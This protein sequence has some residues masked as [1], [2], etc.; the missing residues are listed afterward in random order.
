VAAARA[1]LPAVDPREPVGPHWDPEPLTDAGRA[2]LAARL[3]RARPLLWNA[4]VLDALRVDPGRRRNRGPRPW[5][6]ARKRREPLP[7]RLPDRRRVLLG[8]VAWIAFLVCVVVL[9]GIDRADDPQ[10][11][12][13]VGA[14]AFAVAAGLF[15]HRWWWRRHGPGRRLLRSVGEAARVPGRGLERGVPGPGGRVLVL[16]G[17]GNGRD[18]GRESDR[19]EL[20]H[21]RAAPGEEQGR[22]QVRTLAWREVPRHGVERPE[23][24]AQ[25][26]WVIADD[27][28][29]A[30]GRAERDAG[31]IRRINAALGRAVAARRSAELAREP[32]AW[33]AVLAATGTAALA[34][35]LV[36]VGWN[37]ESGLA[38]DL[39]LRSW[40]LAAGVVLW[41]AAR[42]VHDPVEE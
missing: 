30:T 41:R 4:G 9:G 22:L 16:H 6:G 7:S 26:F 39:A 15:G 36:I 3:V 2:E 1:A 31:T 29:F 33:T 21:V 23:E 14:A 11:N 13:A 34:V 8:W 38:L 32:L 10:G 20:V 5:P 19:V 24:V 27:A 18:D 37:E 28:G 25:Q 40:P 17:R 35:A 42:R 12:R